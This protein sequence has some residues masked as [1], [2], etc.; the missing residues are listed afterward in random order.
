MRFFFSTLNVYTG[1]ARQGE[2]S[3]LAGNASSSMKKQLDAK[4]FPQLTYGGES[5]FFEISSV[6]CY[7]L[8][9]LQW[10]ATDFKNTNTNIIKKKRQPPM[11]FENQHAACVS[12]ILIPL[13]ILFIS[14][15]KLWFITVILI[16]WQF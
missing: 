10:R 16:P 12:L 1:A 2:G 3:F 9:L 8:I 15:L 11:Y 6:F 7:F 5:Y 14:I 4:M 13:V